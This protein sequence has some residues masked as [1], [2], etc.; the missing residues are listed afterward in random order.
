MILITIQSPI[1]SIKLTS[2]FGDGMHLSNSTPKAPIC[3][4]L[5]DDGDC[6]LNRLNF[7]TIFDFHVLVSFDFCSE[8]SA[9]SENLTVNS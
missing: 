8:L 7:L 9:D 3:S 6:E 5:C 4:T 1:V 2:L